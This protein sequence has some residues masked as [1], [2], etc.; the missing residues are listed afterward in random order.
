MMLGA[1][2]DKR[3]LEVGTIAVGVEVV[4]A[5]PVDEESW[6]SLMLYPLTFDEL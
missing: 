4:A 6:V 3:G 5:V 1:F 2:D